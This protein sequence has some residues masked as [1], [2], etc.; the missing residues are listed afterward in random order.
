M[1]HGFRLGR[2]HGVIGGYRSLGGI[3]TP[4]EG[5]EPSLIPRA[6]SCNVQNELGGRDAGLALDCTG[7]SLGRGRDECRNWFGL[8]V[9]LSTSGSA[10][11]GDGHPGQAVSAMFYSGV[12]V[13]RAVWM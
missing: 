3:P 8:I 5:S 2:F 13:V 6:V 4:E 7:C 1:R 12:I 10:G 11:L 9:G